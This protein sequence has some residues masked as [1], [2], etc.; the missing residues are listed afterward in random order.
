MEN[1]KWH[2]SC[3]DCFT[4][5]RDVIRICYNR[6][7]KDV[8]E[9]YYLA[10]LMRATCNDFVIRN[11]LKKANKFVL[12]SVNNIC[13]AR[14][15]LCLYVIKLATVCQPQGPLAALQWARVGGW[16]TSGRSP[17][18]NLTALLPIS[19]QSSALD[20]RP[21]AQPQTAYLGLSRRKFPFIERGYCNP[22]QYQICIFWNDKPKRINVM[23]TP[24]SVH[25]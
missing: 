12:V 4:I 19:S 8:E 13:D 5:L 22:L 3:D 17:P 15:L 24:Y 14:E 25:V 6:I 18:C 11:L 21:L 20:V 1:T 7:A 9:I 16:V 23:A 10:V 2:E